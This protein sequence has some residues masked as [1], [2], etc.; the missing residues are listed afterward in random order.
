M[1]EEILKLRNEGK[2]Y[3]QIKEK[4]GCSKSKIAYYLNNTTKKKTVEKNKKI[5]FKYRKKLKDIKGSCCCLCG[6]S[7]CLA[8][9]QFHHIDPKNKKFGITEA[10]KSKIKVTKQEILEEIEKCILV[11]ANCH[12]EIH[13]PDIGAE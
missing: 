7:K 12:F 1:K 10:I 2:T 13:S 4:L 5:R 3:N 9:L 11:C 8:A 6:Y